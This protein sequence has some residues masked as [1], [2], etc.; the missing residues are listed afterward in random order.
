MD[1]GSGDVVDETRVEGPLDGHN[2][3][4]E[5]AAVDFQYVSTAPPISRATSLKGVMIIDS[6]H[7]FEK[8]KFM[9]KQVTLSNQRTLPMT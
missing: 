7:I 1:L 8:G 9:F 2:M 3:S 6:K 4:R 5:G